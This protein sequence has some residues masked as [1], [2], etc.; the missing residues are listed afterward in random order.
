MLD[1]THNQTLCSTFALEVDYRAPSRE[2]LFLAS[3]WGVRDVG[4]PYI[5]SSSATIIIPNWSSL[6]SACV[7]YNARARFVELFSC[8]RFTRIDHV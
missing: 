6:Q 5:N 2:D 4:G 3:G 8:R 1:V 7:E